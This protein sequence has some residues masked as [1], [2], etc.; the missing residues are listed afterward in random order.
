MKFV[1]LLA[2]VPAENRAFADV[3][4]TLLTPEGVYFQ[5][6]QYLFRWSNG[7]L[8]VWKPPTPLLPGRGRG[9]ARST[10]ASPRPG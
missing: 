5:S 4:R 1:S 6:P 9:T 7:Q 3:W 2:H 8:R 10:S